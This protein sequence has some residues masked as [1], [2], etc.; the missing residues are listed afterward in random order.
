MR[1]VILGSGVVGVTSAWYLSQ[2]GH[3]VTVI[4]RESGPALETSAANA[5]QI[6]R[7]CGTVAAP[8]VPLKAIKWMFQRHAPLAISLDG[9]QFQLKWMWQMLRNCDTTTWRTKGAWCA[10]RNTAATV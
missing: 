1:V 6:S 2:A 8:G 4:D 3:D 5:G 9:T 7:V 10:W